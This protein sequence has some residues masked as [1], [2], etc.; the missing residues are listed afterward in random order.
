MKFDEILFR[1]A[2]ERGTEPRD[3]SF[4]SY[5]LGWKNLSVRVGFSWI[6]HQGTER[7]RKPQRLGQALKFSTLGTSQSTSLDYYKDTGDPL[8]RLR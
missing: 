1:L 6:W 2:E 7:T 5:R 3:G 4:Y 8:S